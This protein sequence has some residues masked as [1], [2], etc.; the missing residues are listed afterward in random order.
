MDELKG[1]KVF[2]GH[3]KDHRVNLDDINTGKYLYTRGG[4]LLDRKSLREKSVKVQN[5]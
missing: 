5:P 3:L 1:Q 4:V 2:M